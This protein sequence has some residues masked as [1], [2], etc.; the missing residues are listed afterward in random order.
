MAGIFAAIAMIISKA[1]ASGDSKK[2]SYVYFSLA[3]LVILICLVT[4]ILMMR[5]VSYIY[6]QREREREIL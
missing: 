2:S 3:I 4:F 1:V 6:T 5:L